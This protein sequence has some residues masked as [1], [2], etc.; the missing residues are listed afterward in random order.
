MAFVVLKVGRAGKYA[1][2]CY[3][4]KYQEIEIFLSCIWWQVNEPSSDDLNG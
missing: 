4:A 3:L 1:G 2:F